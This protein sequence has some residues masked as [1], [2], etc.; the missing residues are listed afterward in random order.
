MNIE[1]MNYFI[2][3]GLVESI[4][5]IPTRETILKVIASEKRVNFDLILTK[6]RPT[7]LVDSRFIYIKLLKHVYGLNKVTIAKELD[8][9]HTTIIH[10]LREFDNRYKYE[11]PFRLVVNKVCLRLGVKLNN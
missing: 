4:E 6:A 10:A 9:D 8:K 7:E 3:P 5:T 1:G 2:L 11:E